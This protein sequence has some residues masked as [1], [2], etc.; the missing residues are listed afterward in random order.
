MSQIATKAEIET[1][2][3][4]MQ[5][6]LEVTVSEDINEVTA[7]GNIIVVHMARSGKLLADAKFH[8]DKQVKESVLNRLELGL[9]PSVLSK[10]IDADCEEENYLVNWMERIN[11]TCTHRLDWARTQISKAKEEMR[12]GNFQT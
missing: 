6:D 3:T 5:S 7:Y 2:A 12:M 9:S 1:E 8:K 10:L 11:R 4:R